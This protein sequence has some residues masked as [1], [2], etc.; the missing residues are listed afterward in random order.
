MKHIRIGKIG[1]RREKGMEYSEIIELPHRKKTK[2][3][4]F[5]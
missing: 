2:K 3:R 5:K 4:R 1:I